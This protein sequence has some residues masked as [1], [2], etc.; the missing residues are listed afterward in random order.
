MDIQS[1]FDEAT[2]TFSHVL[3]DAGSHECA[4]V[5]SVLDYD[6]AAGRVTTRSADIIF[7]YIEANDLKVKYHLETHVHADHL[8]GAQYL[9][10]AL[11]G[12]VVI[13]SQV[14]AVQ[15]IFGARF[16]VAVGGDCFDRL[17]DEGDRLSIGDES[18]T[19]MHTPGHTP[20]CVTYLTAGA[21]FVGDTLFMPDYGTARA[22]FPGGDAAT[23]FD[24]IQKI[25]S[26]PDETLL[27]LCHDYLT[28]D[29]RDFT[30]VTSVREERAGNIHL[31]DCDREAYV[32]MRR[33]R[34]AGLAAPRLLLP[35][36]QFNMQGGRLPAGDD[37]GTRYFRIPLLLDEKLEE[38]GL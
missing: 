28:G 3:S 2:S 37:N 29:R 26:L 14:T 35:S 22:D 21:A 18:I 27:Y 6:P 15:R 20:A 30:C 17:V 24:S 12:E 32:S 33:A 11:G 1:F 31:V 4:I 13:G 23:L 34:D 36:I 10:Q 16:N 38:I 19:V 5:D 25:L 8:S 9:K 7:G